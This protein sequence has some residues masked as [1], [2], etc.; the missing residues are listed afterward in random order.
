MQIGTDHFHLKGETYILVF[1][2]F[3]RYPEIQRLTN[4]TSHN[5]IHALK[6]AFE[7]H[8][9]PET[10]VSKNGP[11]YAS[12]EFANFANKY[13]FAHI[14]SSL[15]FPQSNEQAERT[16]QTIKKLLKEATDLQMALLIYRATPL[17]WCSLSPA[18]L[19]M[20]RRLHSFPNQATHSR[21][22]MPA[23]IPPKD[24]LL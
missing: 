10:V 7:T 21:L 13:N 24:Q 2:Y 9:V 1:D 18:E 23:R 16:V 5:I 19:F 11:H 14:T 22:E 17:P 4:T 20:G 6:T 3:S 15:L 8:G 12:Q